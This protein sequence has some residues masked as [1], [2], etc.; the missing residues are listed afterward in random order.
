[1][2]EQWRIARI[3]DSYRLSFVVVRNNIDERAGCVD[4]FSN[5]YS[6][7]MRFSSHVIQHRDAS[8]WMNL[9]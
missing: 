2:V 6:Y 5:V 7:R 4:N 8:G 3:I 1:M 9:L